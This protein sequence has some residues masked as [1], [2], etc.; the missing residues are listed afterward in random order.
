MSSRSASAPPTLADPD[1]HTISD[2]LLAELRGK[3]WVD[4]SPAD[5]IVRDRVASL[6]SD[7]QTG[8]ERLTLRVAAKNILG[9]RRVEEHIVAPPTRGA[10]PGDGGGQI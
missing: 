1:E 6:V 5:I 3:N 7:D 10:V 8:E 4:I 9:V 2:Q